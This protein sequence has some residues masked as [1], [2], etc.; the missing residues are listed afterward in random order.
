MS[1]LPWMRKWL[2]GLG[3]G[4]PSM[5]PAFRKYWKNA[6][7]SVLSFQV[8]HEYYVTATRK[9]D[10]GLSPAEA[11]SDI[12]ALLAWNPLPADQ[13]TLEAA[14]SIEDAFGVSWWDSPI[15]ASAQAAQARFLLTEDLQNGI[16]FDAVKV[17]NPFQ[18]TYADLK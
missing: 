4:P 15:I 18:G 6:W 2:N 7:R 16:E 8:L 9:L 12:R 3:C 13:A 1:P 10:P 17:V 11:R 5:T 14:W